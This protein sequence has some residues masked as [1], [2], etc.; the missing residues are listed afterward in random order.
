MF[1]FRIISKLQLLCVVVLCSFSNPDD[2]YLKHKKLIKLI[3]IDAGHGGKDPGCLGTISKE[4]D[5]ALKIAIKTGAIIKRYLKDVKVVYTRETDTFI[6]L[7]D[8]VQLANR[9]EASIFLSIH[10][11]AHPQP[12][13]SGT[14]TYVLGLSK[15]LTS[16]REN[17]VIFKEKNYQKNYAINRVE[18]IINANFLS[19]H[20]EQSILLAT[21]VESQLSRRRQKLSHGVKQSRFLVLTRTNMPSILVEV[22]FLTNKREE[23]YLNT[24]HGQNQVAASIYRGLRNYIFK[25][26]HN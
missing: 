22:G 16:R 8:R 9:L 14:E 5:L 3:V 4:K 12:D 2:P 1:K 23:L 11:N 21:E 13:T 24:P 7:I 17:A 20:R 26:E 19:I 25:V 15:S 10:C 18:R 6:P